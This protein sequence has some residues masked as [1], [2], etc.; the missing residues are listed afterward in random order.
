MK[1][2]IFNRLNDSTFDNLTLE[3]KIEQLRKTIQDLVHVVENPE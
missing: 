2:V 1:V 3:E